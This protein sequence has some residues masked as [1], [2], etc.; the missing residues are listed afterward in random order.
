MTTLIQKAVAGTDRLSLTPAEC[1]THS[2]RSSAAMAMHM[3]GVPVYTIMLTG[4]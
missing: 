3:A 1:G 4:R 2:I